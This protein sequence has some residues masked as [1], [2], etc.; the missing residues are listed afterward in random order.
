MEANMLPENIRQAF[1][2]YERMQETHLNS[3]L[4]GADID[5]EK[6]N[7]ER[8][9]AFENLKNGLNE[10]L[11]FIR[12]NGADEGMNGISNAL[13]T[14]L[15]SILKTDAILS[16]KMLILRKEFEQQLNKLNSGKKA[17]KAY[18]KSCRR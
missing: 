8:S 16:E 11:R 1:N 9:R 2:E 14:E 17:L 18:G 12:L 7:Y 4:S 15:Q 5:I 6:Q 3:I 10:M 13:K